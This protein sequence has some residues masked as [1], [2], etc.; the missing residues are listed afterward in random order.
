MEFL[1]VPRVD[2][3]PPPLLLP[4]PLP[5]I[6]QGL[7]EVL[8]QAPTRSRN[9]LASRRSETS[10]TGSLVLPRSQ[11]LL[12]SPFLPF[13]SVSLFVVLFQCLSFSFLYVYLSFNFRFFSLLFYFYI[14]SVYVYTFFLGP[15]LCFCFSF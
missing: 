6:L 4:L 2:E 15:C 5:Q 13:F 11:V 9:H 8:T 3:A 14:C 7:P 12:Y 1:R 10:T